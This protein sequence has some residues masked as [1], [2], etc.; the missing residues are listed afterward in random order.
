MKHYINIFHTIPLMLFIIYFKKSVECFLITP[1]TVPDN[2]QL[3]ISS[4]D[5]KDH[6]L[7]KV[8]H[9]K[10]CLIYVDANLVKTLSICF[11]RMV[12]N[13]EFS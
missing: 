2:I 3:F 5:I 1:K 10:P 12:G 7:D 6:D 8:K 4:Y 13:T 11:S 9:N